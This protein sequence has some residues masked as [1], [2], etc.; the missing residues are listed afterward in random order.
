MKEETSHAKHRFVSIPGAQLP[1]EG[2][3][4]ILPLTP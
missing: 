2:D 3:E 4:K 1:G